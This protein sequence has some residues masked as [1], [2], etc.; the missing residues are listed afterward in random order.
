MEKSK[1]RFKIIRTALV[2]VFH[3][4]FSKYRES[5]DLEAAGKIAGKMLYAATMS[6]IDEAGESA[7]PECRRIMK[8]AVSRGFRNCNGD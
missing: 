5:R 3:R 6:A 4:C 8:D 7:C 2:L 1:N